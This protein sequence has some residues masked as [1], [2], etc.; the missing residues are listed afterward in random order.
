MGKA[1]S[2]VLFDLYGTL[3]DV[4]SVAG[5]AD[6]LFPGR[7]SALSQLWRDKQLEYTRLRTMSSRYVPFTQVVEDALQYACDALH[8]PL[9]SAGRGLLMHEFTQLT[10]FADAVPALQR[11]LA[12]DLTVGVLTNGDPGQ[13]EDA[14]HGAGLDDYFDVLLSADQARAYK[15]APAVYELG[16]LTLGHPAA[17]LLLISS[18]GWDAI[19]A[20]WYGYRSFW[21]NRSSAPIERLDGQPDGIGRSLSDAVD[22]ALRLHSGGKS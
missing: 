19:G 7:G 17:E 1:L 10:P 20:K 14:L 16:P 13:M 3:L 12:A 9:D 18:N 5:R 6:Q 4:H 15:T 2:A 8:L 11:L 22:F 21:V